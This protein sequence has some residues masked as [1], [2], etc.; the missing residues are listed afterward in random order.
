ML[1]TMLETRRGSDDGH[2]VRQFIRGQK[3][4]VADTLA[5]R[6][7]NQGW[8]YNSEAFDASVGQSYHLTTDRNGTEEADKLATELRE[9]GK[10]L[11]ST[12][13]ILSG[14]RKHRGQWRKTNHE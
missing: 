3:Y 9:W 11:L 13:L 6:F 10:V 4:D 12:R 2:T 5:V 7:L 14:Y 1:I 8:A